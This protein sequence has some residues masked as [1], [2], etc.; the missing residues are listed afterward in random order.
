MIEK[1]RPVTEMVAEAM[2]PS[3]S[4]AA[5]GPPENTKKN[6]SLAS[7]ASNVGTITPAARAATTAT[8]GIIQNGPQS[9]C[10]RVSRGTSGTA[11]RTRW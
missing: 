11:P 5:S 1:T 8:A 3:T 6:G 10:Q 4:R 2:T 7:R 9:R